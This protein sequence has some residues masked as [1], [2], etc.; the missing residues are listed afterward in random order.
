MYWR[1]PGPKCLYAAACEAVDPADCLIV[2]G[3]KEMNVIPLYLDKRP[4]AEIWTVQGPTRRWRVGDPEGI[5]QIEPYQDMVA[6]KPVLWFAVYLGNFLAYRI[7]ADCVYVV[8]KCSD[9]ETGE[10]LSEQRSGGSSAHAV[11]PQLDKAERVTMLAYEEARLRWSNE[12]RLEAQRL[13]ERVRQESTYKYPG[14]G[15]LL[16]RKRAKR[17]LARRQGRFAQPTCNERP[18]RQKIV[19]PVHDDRFPALRRKRRNRPLEGWGG[20]KGM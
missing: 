1:C 6:G 8:Y 5:T 10:L 14:D 9:P 20:D 16:R 15:E 11:P 3:A 2:K 4:I 7:P 18:L 13:E 17:S 19:F 12:Q